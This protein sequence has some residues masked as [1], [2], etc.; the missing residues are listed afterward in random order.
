MIPVFHLALVTAD[1][2]EPVYFPGGSPIEHDLLAECVTAV[3]ARVSGVGVFRTE[4]HVKGVVESA[5]R[6]GIAEAVWNFKKL[7]L[8]ALQ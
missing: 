1:R 4:A 3:M 6:E 7:S 2:H 5:V 8:N